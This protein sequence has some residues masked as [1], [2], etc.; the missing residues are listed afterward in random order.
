VGVVG[1]QRPSGGLHRGPVGLLRLSADHAA[2]VVGSR[3][4]P[5]VAVHRLLRYHCRSRLL[6]VQGTPQHLSILP[7][8]KIFYLFQV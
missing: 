8:D 4:T 1:G 3:S 2:V 6:S 7:S 5:I